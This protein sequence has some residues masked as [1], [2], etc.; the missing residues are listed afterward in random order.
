MKNDQADKDHK[1]IEAKQSDLEH[2]KL[3][4]DKLKTDI[5]TQRTEHDFKL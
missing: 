4:I 3:D 2:A 1:L 5:T